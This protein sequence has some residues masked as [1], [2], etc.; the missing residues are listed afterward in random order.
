MPKDATANYTRKR[1]MSPRACDRRSFRV[2][3][4]KG[5]KLLTV[6]C[7]RGKWDAKRGKCRTGTKGQSVATPKGMGA[8]L[9]EIR[10]VRII[11]ER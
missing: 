9:D 8:P 10:S 2:K 4:L 3:R 7:P 5:G 1:L 11:P 6:C